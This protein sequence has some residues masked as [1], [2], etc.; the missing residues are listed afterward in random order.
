MPTYESRQRRYG[1]KEQTVFGV[2]ENAAAAVTEITCEPFTIDPDVMIH[3]LPAEHGSRHPVEQVTKHSVQGSA[4]RFSVSGPFDL[5]YVDQIIYAHTQKVVELAD[6]EFTKTFTLF[7]DHPDFSLDAGHFLTWYRRQP[8]TNTSQIVGSCI[9]PRLKIFGERDGFI[10]FESDWISVG[11]GNDVA[12]PGGTW[13]PVTGAS[14]LMF[15]DLQS[16]TLSIGVGLTSPVALTLRSFEIET[17]HEAEKIGHS[18]SLGFESFGLKNRSGSFKIN[19]LRDAIADEAIISLKAGELIQFSLDFGVFTAQI[20]GKIE[21]IE[22]D[23]E[24]LLAES[25]T[26]RMFASYTAGAWG[27]P[28]TYVIQ[29]DIDRSWPA[30]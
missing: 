17:V 10:H 30:A 14:I 29:N 9:A 13:T 16:A 20:S 18:A 22:A 15:N 2:P 4:A 6:T 23:A 25:L 28:L 11:S 7:T 24:G 26:C 8:A 5:G 19:L 12:S 27:T 3:E 21:S 1:F